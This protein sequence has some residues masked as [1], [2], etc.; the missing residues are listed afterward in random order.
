MSTIPGSVR[1]AGFMAPT[2]STDTYAV[3]DPTYGRGSLRSVA[4]ITARN[5]I[6]LDRRSGQLGMEVV[7]VDTMKKYRLINE[8]GTPNT[9]DTDWQEIVASI[10]AYTNAT[11]TP[12]TIGGIPAGSTFSSVANN[13]MWT[14]LLYP[15]QYPAFTGFL[16]A[17]QPI[18]DRRKLQLANSSYEYKSRCIQFK[19]SS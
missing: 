11:P 14:S 16:I 17:G 10:D 8:P 4:D 13:D 19:L 9:T 1:V 2:D 7:T 5:A 15:Y 3:T 12:V 18:S 6:T